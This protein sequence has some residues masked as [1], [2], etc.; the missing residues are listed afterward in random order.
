MSVM[1]LRSTR[2]MDPMSRDFPIFLELR[3]FHN[4]KAGRGD[5]NSKAFV[6]MK[7]MMGSKT[8]PTE[9]LKWPF[10]TKAEARRHWLAEA[11]I[12]EDKGLEKLDFKIDGF[13]EED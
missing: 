13:H 12:L 10:G 1:C 4:I 3:R 2:F 6:V 7:R 9:T 8:V 11:F 5:K